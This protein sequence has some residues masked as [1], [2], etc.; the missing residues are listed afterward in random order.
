MRTACETWIAVWVDSQALFCVSGARWSWSTPATKRQTKSWC[1]DQCAGR[2]KRSLKKTGEIFWGAAL[3]PKRTIYDNVRLLWY[4]INY[5]FTRHSTTVFLKNF[6]TS[7]A[8]RCLLGQEPAAASEAAPE[9]EAPWSD[10]EVTLLRRMKD[11][12]KR[13]SW[14]A[15]AKRLN[16]SE[17]SVRLKWSNLKG[18]EDLDLGSEKQNLSWDVIWACSCH[19]VTYSH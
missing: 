6:K 17:T 5:D 7:K 10:E 2:K 15:I 3:Q 13:W 14:P 16:R 11:P 19:G 12:A 9:A 8:T 4:R 1:N 18:G